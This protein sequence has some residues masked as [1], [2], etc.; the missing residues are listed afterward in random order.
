M[1][2]RGGRTPW[3]RPETPVHRGETEEGSEPQTGKVPL[4]PGPLRHGPSEKGALEGRLVSNHRR[5][6]FVD[7]IHP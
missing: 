5:V 4:Y 2:N 3:G 1:K 7:L 6:S